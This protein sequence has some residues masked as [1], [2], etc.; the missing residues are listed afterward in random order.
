MRQIRHRPVRAARFQIFE[1]RAAGGDG[2]RFRADE[3]AAF[4]VERR[5][6][7]DDDFLRLQIRIEHAARAFERLDQLHREMEQIYDD[8]AKPDADID[9]LMKRQVKIEEE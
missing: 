6:A 2:Q 1:L 3:F 8:M 5:V 4:H 9:A 7:D